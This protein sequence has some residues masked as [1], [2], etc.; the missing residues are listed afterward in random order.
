MR[1]PS[2]PALKLS[3]KAEY[4]L[5]ALLAIASD[6]GPGPVSVR[7]LAEE[8]AL[9]RKFLEAVMRDLRDGGLVHSAPG[10]QGGYRLAKPA[11]S[12]ALREVF[13]AVGYRIAEEGAPASD[14]PVGEDPVA[15]FMKDLGDEVGR[16]VRDTRLSDVLRGNSLGR[17][18]GWRGQ[19][20]HGDGI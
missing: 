20:M 6:P 14:A 16:L 10:K 11:A 1:R 4:A 8:Q 17:A 15:G 13:D 12:I 5:R 7:R 2:P 3:K 18:I 9:P 19:Y